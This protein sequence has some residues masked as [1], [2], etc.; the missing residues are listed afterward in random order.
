LRDHCE[1][2][3]D[4]RLRAALAIAANRHDGDR[5]DTSSPTAGGLSGATA[6]RRHRVRLEPGSDDHTTAVVGVTSTSAAAPP[7]ICTSSG[8]PPS[9]LPDRTTWGSA[10][11]DCRIPAMRKYA[12]W[13]VLRTDLEVI[14]STGRRRKRPRRGHDCSRRNRAAP[15][16]QCGRPPSALQSWAHLAGWIQTVVQALGRCVGTAA[17]LHAATRAL[18]P[19]ICEIPT[20]GPVRRPPYWCVAG[21]VRS[22]QSHRSRRGC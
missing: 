6:P 9:S 4:S 20:R 14:G 3:A 15:P 18:H 11:P 10:G 1:G 2:R 12:G 22:Q 21:R 5:P 8:P 16:Y 19:A 17:I 7:R 13:P